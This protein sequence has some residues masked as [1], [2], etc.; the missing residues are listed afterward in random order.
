MPAQTSSNVNQVHVTGVYQL[1]SHIDKLRIHLWDLIRK[2]TRTADASCGLGARSRTG[3]L[4]NDV[5]AK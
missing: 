1:Y 5:Q 4:A 3:K 2:P